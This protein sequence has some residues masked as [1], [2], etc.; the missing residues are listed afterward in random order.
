MNMRMRAEHEGNRT[1]AQP[2]RIRLL[3]SGRVQG[4]GF[5]FGAADQARRLGLRGWVK[6]L[7]DGRV[8]IVA[9]GKRGALEALRAW[10]YQ[11]PPAARVT[12]VS[13]QWLEYRGEP[14]SFGIR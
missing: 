8:E 9:E 14:A 4:V 2:A 10:S 1:Q 5:R 7:S 11:G 13:E 3:I 12:D 6:N